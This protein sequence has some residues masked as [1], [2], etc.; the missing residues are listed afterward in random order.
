[1]TPGETVII[2]NKGLSFCLKVLDEHALIFDKTT[3]GAVIR[4]LAVVTSDVPENEYGI[5]KGIKMLVSDKK[6]E[7]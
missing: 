6:E 4:Q 7:E 1:M 3:G 2:K 5:K